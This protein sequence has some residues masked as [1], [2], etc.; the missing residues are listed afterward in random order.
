MHDCLFPIGNKVVKPNCFIPNYCLCAAGCGGGYWGAAYLWVAPLVCCVCAVCVCMSKMHDNIEEKKRTIDMHQ[1]FYCRSPKSEQGREFT[2]LCGS[3]WWMADMDPVRCSEGVG[4]CGCAGLVPWRLK[5]GLAACLCA[6]GQ[7]PMV[8]LTWC[9]WDTQ[10]RLM[11]FLLVR[12]HRN[13][14]ILFLVS[15]SAWAYLGLGEV[16]VMSQ[17]KSTLCMSPVSVDSWKQVFNVENG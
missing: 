13:A 15:S 11:L 3:S 4:S 1:Y 6:A 2:S 12:V 10:A 7:V 9:L 16:A 17:V 8:L 5:R 14:I